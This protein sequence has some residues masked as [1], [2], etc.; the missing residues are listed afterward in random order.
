[1]NSEFTKGSDGFPELITVEPEA[2]ISTRICPAFLWFPLIK[3]AFLEGSLL[4]KFLA[5]K[6]TLTTKGGVAEKSLNTNS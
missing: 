1:M 4:E 6:S 5:F 3:K 2:E